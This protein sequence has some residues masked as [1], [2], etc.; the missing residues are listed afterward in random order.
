MKVGRE[1]GAVG[2]RFMLLV[3]M[4]TARASVPIPVIFTRSQ[5]IKCLKGKTIRDSK[6][7][8]LTG[9]GDRELFKHYEM[10]FLDVWSVGHWG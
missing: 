10:G 6:T 7:Y 3:R 9:E 5:E 8:G 2:Q 4:P 1:V